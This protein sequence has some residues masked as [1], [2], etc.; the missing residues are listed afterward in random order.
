M[1]V[2]THSEMQPPLQ[3]RFKKYAHFAGNY[4][5]AWWN[6]STS[7]EV[8]RPI[9]S[10]RNASCPRRKRSG[11]GYLPPFRRVPGMPAYETDKNG[12]KDFSEIIA[13]AIRCLLR[14][15]SDWQHCRRFCANQVMALADKVV[16]AVKSGHRK[17]FVMAAARK[18]EFQVV[19]HEFSLQLRRTR[20]PHAGSAKIPLKQAGSRR[21]REY[22]G[23]G[24]RTVQ[25]LLF[26]CGHRLEAQGS[27]RLRESTSCR[28]LQ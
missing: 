4:G 10:R 13:L 19:L 11:K 28:S 6:R 15:R 18:E 26:A 22:R 17:F 27:I 2:Y 12:N 24:R 5:N 23:I 14:S 20:H 7:C 25:R 16:E 1:D 8:P 9:P 21:N 3:P